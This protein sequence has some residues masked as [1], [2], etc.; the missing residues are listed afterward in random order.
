MNWHIFNFYYNPICSIFT[1]LHLLFH[2]QLLNA[3]LLLR[4]TMKT[5][6]FS[7][8][9]H[10]IKLSTV[11]LFFQRIV[12]TIPSEKKV[13]EN[14]LGGYSRAVKIDQPTQNIVTVFCQHKGRQYHIK[15]QYTNLGGPHRINTHSTCHVTDM[16]SVTLILYWQLQSPSI[17][18][19]S[20]CIM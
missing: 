11:D 19:E 4:D 12:K 13:C 9:S 20:G 10:H 7:F 8:L 17:S 1:S 2:C 5:D 18:D 3:L 6:F 16:L 14:G 15:W